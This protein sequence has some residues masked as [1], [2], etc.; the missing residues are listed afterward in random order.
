[1]DR[2]LS[3]RQPLLSAQA[4]QVAYT[5]RYRAGAA[6]TDRNRFGDTPRSHVHLTPRPP[7]TTAYKNSRP[8]PKSV[9][10]KKAVPQMAETAAQ[11]NHSPVV[12][13]EAN[14]GSAAAPGMTADTLVYRHTEGCE[15][16]RGL[17]RHYKL[18]DGSCVHVAMQPES[19]TTALPSIVSWQPLPAPLELEHVFQEAWPSTSFLDALVRPPTD[20]VEHWDASMHP[21]FP[22]AVQHGDT[23]SDGLFY[24][25]FLCAP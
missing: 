25:M 9:R 15:V 8:Q 24:F 14:R 11:R 10:K 22:G 2:G 17:Y 21:A 12:K 18:S 23:A 5:S 20:W 7:R 19:N 4:F 1:V 13:P 3:R 6:T 16:C